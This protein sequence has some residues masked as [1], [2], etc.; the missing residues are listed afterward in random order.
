MNNLGNDSMN[1]QVSSTP[2]CYTF[3]CPPLS[4]QV[5]TSEDKSGREWLSMRALRLLGSVIRGLPK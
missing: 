4:R 2:F 5:Q 3:M 1:S